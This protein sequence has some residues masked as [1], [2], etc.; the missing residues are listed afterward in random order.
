MKTVIGIDPGGK[1]AFGW[2]VLRCSERMRALEVVAS[3]VNSTVSEVIGAVLAVA[4][5]SDPEFPPV[6][7]GIDA[8]LYWVKDRERESDRRLRQAVSRAGGHSATVAH[9]NSLRGACL[10]QGILVAD[11]V[12]RAWPKAQVTEAHPKA[13]ILVDKGARD[14]SESIVFQTEHERDAA[15]G[16]YAAAA[17]SQHLPGWKD[18]VAEES[19]PF[20]PLGK[21][22]VYWSPNLE[23]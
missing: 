10:V 5:T 7:V 20:F 2:C 22:V 8:P 16:A 9:V 6:G 19:S 17:H 21:R 14:F 23:Q 15:L 1:C 4:K 13:L 18:W 12:F 11:E 3:G